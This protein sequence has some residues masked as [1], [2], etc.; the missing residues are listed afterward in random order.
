MKV[1]L[2]IISRLT[3][4]FE[5]INKDALVYEILNF[6]ECLRWHYIGTEL[7]SGEGDG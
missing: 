4:T 1:M 5:I 6:F 2:L 3:G 7:G